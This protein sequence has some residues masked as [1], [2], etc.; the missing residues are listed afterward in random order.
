MAHREQHGNREAKKPRKE[1]KGG[2]QAESTTGNIS[3]AFAAHTKP[4]H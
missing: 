3:E 1:P 2:S 4:K